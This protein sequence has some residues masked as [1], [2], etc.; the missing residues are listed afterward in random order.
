MFSSEKSKIFLPIT[1]VRRDTSI[2][3][4]RHSGDKDHIE[5]A[6]GHGVPTS[7]VDGNS[8]NLVVGSAVQFL[9]KQYGVIKW[10][11]TLPGGDKTYAGVEMVGH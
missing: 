3:Q 9:D 5:T 4:N 10:I 8:Q 2:S 11:G 6:H 7:K 1:F